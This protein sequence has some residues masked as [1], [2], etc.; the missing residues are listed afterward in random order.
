MRATQP[1]LLVE[2][3]TV[4]LLTHNEVELEV[5][6]HQDEDTI[7]SD[8]CARTIADW[9]K[10]PAAHD[11]C[12]VRLAQGDKLDQLWTYKLQERVA[13][14]AFVE[15]TLSSGSEAVWN[16]KCLDALYY[17]AREAHKLAIR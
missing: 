4:M 10:T 16:I 6:A 15:R 5:S 7:I 8:E 14:L 12:L 11:E 3:S 2:G 1:K 13:T 17:W 9:W